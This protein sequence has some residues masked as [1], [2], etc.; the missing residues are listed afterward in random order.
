MNNPINWFEISTNDLERA[1]RFWETVL[2]T[3]LKRERFGDQD[4]AIFPRASEGGIAGALVRDERRKPA[5]QGTCVFLNAAPN[6]DACIAR[7]AA[8]GGKVVV[9]KTDIGQPGFIALV[10]DTVGNAVGL[11]VERS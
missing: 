4:L 5:S 6:I 1:S 8:A 7:V 9:P 2:A 10:V 11:H 3:R